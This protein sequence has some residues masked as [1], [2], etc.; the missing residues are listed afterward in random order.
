[1]KSSGKQRFF[2]VLSFGLLA[3]ACKARPTPTI[4]PI[5]PT[6][7]PAPPT[8]TPPPPTVTPSAEWKLIWAD[9][10]DL[11][12]GSPVDS[13]QWVHN[14]GGGGWG[15]VE[16]EFY[17]DRISNSFIENGMLVIQAIKEKYGNYDYTSARIRTKR[18]IGFVYGRVEI[19]ARLPNTQGIWPA[20]WM[21]SSESKY[22]EWPMSGEIDIMEMIGRE[23]YRSYGALHYGNPHEHQETHYDLT[24]GQ[25]FADDFHTFA[26]EWEPTEIRWYVDGYH[27]FT[28]THWFSSARGADY[29]APFDQKFDIIMNV[30]VGGSWPGFPD[31]SSTFPQAMHV[32]Y[33]RVYQK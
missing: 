18:E 8:A 12:D 19:R 31:S 15:N 29:P 7:T 21:L 4:T 33:V 22:G 25:T 13:T 16:L 1:M 26:I 32:D 20:I 2:A 27:C 24:G 23:P 5:P 9:E 6:A 11:A 17:T 28:A 10:F 14:T 30:A 3:F